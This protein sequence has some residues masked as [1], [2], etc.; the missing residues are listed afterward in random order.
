MGVNNNQVI[1]FV[2]GAWHGAWCWEHYFIPYFKNKG[3]RAVTFNLPGHN[4]P[5]N[6]KGINQYRIKDYVQALRSVA[7]QWDERLIIVG[8]SM[9][10]LV[11]QKYLEKYSCHRA[12][13]LA[14]VPK[15]GVFQVTWKF[16]TSR[17]YTLPNLLR[18]N[19]FGL[20]N[21]NAKAKWALYSEDVTEE[22]LTL[23]R[24]NLSGE[25][26]LAF[27]NMIVPRIKIN[28]HQKIPILVLSAQEDRLFTLKEHKATAQSYNA[29]W[30]VI[31]NIAHNMML[32]SN[33][34]NAADAI[35][36][37]IDD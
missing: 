26:F 22:I 31:P 6:P 1:L 19:L 36:D 24:I 11:L 14:T 5:G 37:W 30:Q 28:F 29:D 25:S 35:I 13:L 9:G 21:N 18:L 27:L 7:K 4:Q 23:S 12:I 17:W 16:L 33:W 20:V 34:K 8:H 10:G 32:E 2:H 3:F 15:S